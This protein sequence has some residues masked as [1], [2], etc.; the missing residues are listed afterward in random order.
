MPVV[1]TGPRRPGSPIP[2][3]VQRPITPSGRSASC[4]PRKLRPDRPARRARWPPPGGDLG[5]MDLGAVYIGDRLGLYRGLERLGPATSAQLAAETGAHERYV[6]EWLEQRAAS[7]LLEVD[8]PARSAEARRG[9]APCRPRPARPPPG[10][11]V[12]PGGQCGGR[13][14]LVGDRHRAGLPEGTGGRARPGR[15]VDRA[16]AVE[17]GRSG[18]RRPRHDERPRRGR[19]RAGG[20]VRSGD[21][22]RGAPRHVAPGRGRP[23]PRPYPPTRGAPGRRPA[24]T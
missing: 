21:D 11:P 17:R 5:L 19:P 9:V 22:R 7:G 2:D 13:G 18:S 15:A 3:G 4:D 14:R 6:R 16:G 1:P 10:R 20:P 8:D 12:G 24:P 23:Y